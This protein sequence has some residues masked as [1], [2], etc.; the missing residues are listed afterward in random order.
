MPRITIVF[1]SS[2]YSIHNVDEDLQ[3]EYDSVV[4]TDLYDIVLFS[5]D[6]WFNENKLVIDKNPNELVQAVYRG[7]MMQP[8]LYRL[9]Y[10]NLLKN[11]IQLITSPKQYELFHIFPNIYSAFENDTAKM[12]IYPD[13]NVKLDEVKRTFKRFMVK[14]YVKSVKGTEFPKYFDNDVEQEEFEKQMKVFFKYRSGLFTGG[15]CIKEYLDL[16]RYNGKTN[17]YRVFYIN[18]EIASIIRNSG[19]GIYTPLP[20]D[21]FIRKYK[22]LCSPFYTIDYA[23]LSDETWKIIEAGDGQVSGLSDSQDNNAF[24]RALYHSLKSDVSNS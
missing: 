10:E 22:N 17:E 3:S 23:E 20:S 24:F 18:G 21:E 5:Y 6:K 9:F 14:D 8:D 15:I 16:K 4:E 2:Y 11:N 19:Q 12:L 13:G 1:P 7:W